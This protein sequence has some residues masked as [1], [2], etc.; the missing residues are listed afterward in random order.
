MGKKPDV[1]QSGYRSGFDEPSRAA[2]E[3][4]FLTGNDGIIDLETAARY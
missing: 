4:A 1:E 3:V 2:Y